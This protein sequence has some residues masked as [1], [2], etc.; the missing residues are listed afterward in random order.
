M[1][2]RQAISLRSPANQH[3]RRTKSGARSAGERIIAHIDE[4]AARDYEN[5]APLV[6]MFVPSEGVLAAAVSGAPDLTIRAQNKGVVLASPLMLLLY[7]R[8]YAF[9]WRQLARE[10]NVAQH[11]ADAAQELYKRFGTFLE[12]FRGVGK[13]LA[14]AAEC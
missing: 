4:L 12:H 9:G 7:L 14:S 2:R 8:S 1:Q 10:E 11:I 6:I 13:H 5:V 3:R